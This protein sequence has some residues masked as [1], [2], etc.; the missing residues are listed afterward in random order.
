M[1]TGPDMDLSQDNSQEGPV[2]ERGPQQLREEGFRLE[3]SL[4]IPDIIT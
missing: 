3:V 4:P 1:L 2:Q